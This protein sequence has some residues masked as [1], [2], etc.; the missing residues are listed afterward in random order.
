MK[1]SE[2]VEFITDELME[3]YEKRQYSNETDL[4]F[5]TRHAKGLLAM[6]EGMGMLPPIVEDS[7]SIAYCEWEPEDEKK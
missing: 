1:R 3:I 4:K 2:M 6:I 5:F 7:A